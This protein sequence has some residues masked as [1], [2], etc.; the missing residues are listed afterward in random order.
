MTVKTLLQLNGWVLV[1]IGTYIILS[2]VGMLS[3]YGLQAELS[4]GLLS[5]LR[6]PGALL[7]SSGLFII[8]SAFNSSRHEQGFYL[9]VL[10]YGSY[11][12]ARALGILLDGIPQIEIVAALAV[13]LTL[14]GL[15]LAVLRSEKVLS[16]SAVST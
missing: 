1:L 14:C 10:V 7:L 8:H 9:S 6:A 5:E 2:P 4:A 13:E 16:H 3:P 15:S 11:A 12:S